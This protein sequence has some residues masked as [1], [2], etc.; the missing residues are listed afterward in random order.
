MS[1]VDM[2]TQTGRSRQRLR[3]EADSL[4]KTDGTDGRSGTAA[5][6]VRVLRPLCRAQSVSCAA[7]ALCRSCRPPSK[8]AILDTMTFRRDAPAPML[9][10][11]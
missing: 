1:R 9:G 4:L 6:I 7:C 11:R 5:V 10:G 2:S 3:L 8:M